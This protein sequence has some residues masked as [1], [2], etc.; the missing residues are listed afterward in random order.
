MPSNGT[1]SRVL[2]A[3]AIEAREQDVSVR[4]TGPVLMNNSQA[5]RDVAIA[6]AGLLL[7]PDFVVAD[8]LAEGRLVRV[9]PEWLPSSYRVFGVSPPDRYGAPKTRAFVDFVAWA[10]ARAQRTSSR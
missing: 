5:L 10:L 4:V 8:A 1:P 9:L 3:D 6:G 7:A 2:V